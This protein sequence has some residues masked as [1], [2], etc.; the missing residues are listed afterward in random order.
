MYLN[1]CHNSGWNGSI[2]ISFISNQI[3][4]LCQKLFSCSDIVLFNLWPSLELYPLHPRHLL[5]LHLLSTV[6]P[7]ITLLNIRFS[8]TLQK[9]WGLHP[10]PYIFSFSRSQDLIL[11]IILLCICDVKLCATANLNPC[12][13]LNDCNV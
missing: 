10:V 13:L 2:R 3:I 6:E 9:L 11:F 1:L 8:P 12:I 5:H 7:S 4:V